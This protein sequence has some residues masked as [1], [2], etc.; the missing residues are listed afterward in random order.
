M[1]DEEWLR[2]AQSDQSQAR[3]DYEHHIPL[4]SFDGGQEE[5]TLVFATK[6]CVLLLVGVSQAAF[7]SYLALRHGRISQQHLLSPASH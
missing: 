7:R 2:E 1:R 4:D 3:W 6:C 5:A